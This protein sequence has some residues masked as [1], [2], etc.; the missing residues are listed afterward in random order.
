MLS[1]LIT[2][3]QLYG[4]V[5]AILVLLAASISVFTALTWVSGEGQRQVLS[6]HH[7]HQ[8]RYYMV[9]LKLLKAGTLQ[10]PVS[11]AYC[12]PHSIAVTEKHN[13][14]LI[15]L[16][17]CQDCPGLYLVSS[18]LLLRFLSRVVWARQ[19]REQ[20]LEVSGLPSAEAMSCMVCNKIPPCF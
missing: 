6:H 10:L 1:S 9:R 7:H 15:N 2:A 17:S 3:P 12:V 14:P 4:S 5:H 8:S 13:H 19:S 18:I 20:A 11:N 16:K